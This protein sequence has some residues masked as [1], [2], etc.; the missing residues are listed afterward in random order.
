LNRT[1][2]AVQSKDQ[3]EKTPE[4]SIAKQLA[5][6]ACSMI[7]DCTALLKNI[8]ASVRGAARIDFILPAQS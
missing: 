2:P 8:C 5:G 1:A 3:N 4:S 6:D 7:Q